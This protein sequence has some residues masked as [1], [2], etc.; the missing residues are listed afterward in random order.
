MMFQLDTA[1]VVFDGKIKPIGRS[2][3]MGR[4]VSKKNGT[5][6]LTGRYSE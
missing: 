6:L 1:G 2:E 4:D 5:A 3:Q